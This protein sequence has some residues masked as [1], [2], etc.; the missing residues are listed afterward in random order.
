MLRVSALLSFAALAACTASSA[1]VRPP[2]DQ[3]FWPTG[4]AM[5]P[6]E[7][8]LF[9]GNANS[10]LRYDTGT[11]DIVD[12]NAVEQ[13]LVPWATSPTTRVLA[14]GCVEDT[15]F[16]ETQVCDETPFI[17]ADEG[18]R[19]GNF[20][21]AIGLQEKD[22]ATGALRLVVPVRGDP[23]ITWADWDQ[24]SQHLVCDDGTGGGFAECDDAHRLTFLR[25]DVNLAPIADEPFDVFVDSANQW[26]AVTHLTQGTVTLV[27][28]PKDTAPIA[29]DEAI[30]LFNADATTGGIGSSAVAGRAPGD[31]NDILYVGSITED[32]VQ[33]LSV[34]R[35]RDGSPAVLD[36]DQF[37]FLDGVGNQSGS[38]E[39][40]RGMVFGSGGDR[41]YTVN[42]LPP[43]LMMYDTS[44][45]AQG[46]PANTL[47]AAT[48]ICRQASRVFLA[49]SGDGDRVYV[50]CFGDGTIYVIDP[51]DG[52]QVEDVISVGHGPYDVVASPSKKRLYVTNYL[53]DTVAVV[54][55][56]PGSVTRNRVVMRL[57]QPKTT[58]P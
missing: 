16:T 39:D 36:P 56:T 51:R 42:R 26:A 57:G 24:T 54:D 1:E 4:L 17:K 5:S 10:D 37:F 7:S 50:S 45:N 3:F 33:T 12:L 34:V 47:L 11:I 40:N 18:I 44:I 27:D 38:S 53:E 32:R 15:D 6:D 55:I 23:S 21:T 49:D 20:S 8:I 41:M 52:L 28:L 43:S 25:N 46:T 13:A 2:A 14:A 29:T 31:P 9:V 19:T 35:P 22:P 30:G 58:T 48:D